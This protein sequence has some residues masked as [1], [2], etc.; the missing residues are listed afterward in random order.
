MVS[1]VS[2]S[3]FRDLVFRN[4]DEFCSHNTNATKS[5]GIDIG[6]D[7]KRHMFLL[8]RFLV[9]QPLAPISGHTQGC[10]QPNRDGVLKIWSSL[11]SSVTAFDSL[12][13]S[14]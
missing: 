10:L 1:G 13:L 6:V 7:S 3:G 14:C 12:R 8:F 11:R 9:D 5:K 2:G 4:R